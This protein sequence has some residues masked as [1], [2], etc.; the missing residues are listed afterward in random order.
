MTDEKTI[1]WVDIDV[2]YNQGHYL[3]WDPFVTQFKI[4]LHLFQPLNID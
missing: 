3:T 1:H 2:D 4:H